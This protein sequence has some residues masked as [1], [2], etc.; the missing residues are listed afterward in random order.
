MTRRAVV[1]ACLGGAAWLA[2]T[3]PAPAGDAGGVQFF[4]DP[5]LFEQALLDAGKLGKGQWDF[6]PDLLPSDVLVPI[7]DVL[8]IDT[9]PVNAPGVWS[10]G[11][12]TDLW[13]PDIDNVRFASNTSPQGP[14]QPRGDDGLFYATAPYLGLSNNV[15]GASVAADSVAIVSG[16]PAGDG[17]CA[18]SFDVLT[19]P[20]SGFPPPVFHIAAYDPDGLPMGELVLDGATGEKAF[21]GIITADPAGLIGRVEIWDASGGP[22]GI[23]SFALYQQVP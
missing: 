5:E 11:A 21:V 12:G 14:L 22:E 10:D 1:A 3:R 16:P 4:A 13:P 17:H 15:L 19:N 6:E 7:D 2:A 20:G 9:H 8:D 23:S 18:I